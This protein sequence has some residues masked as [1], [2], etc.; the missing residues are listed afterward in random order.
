MHKIQEKAKAPFP[1]K[2]LH[3]KYYNIYRDTYYI[4]IVRIRIIHCTPQLYLFL[5]CSLTPAANN[6][7]KRYFL[8]FRDAVLQH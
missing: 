5:E 1:L 4:H 6:F 8:Q 7:Q 3:T 2:P